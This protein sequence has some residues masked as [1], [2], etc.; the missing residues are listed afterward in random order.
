MKR[1]KLIP[2]VF[3]LLFCWCLALFKPWQVHA[4]VYGSGTWTIGQSS[5][6]CVRRNVSSYFSLT[7]SA[8][9]AG[10]DSLPSYEWGSGLRFTNITVPKGAN[11]TSAN[12][13]F[14]AKQT[15]NWDANWVLSTLSA[16]DS[17]N[18]VTFSNSS[19]DFDNNFS[20]HT[21]A[22][23][24]WDSNTLWTINSTYTSPDISSVLQVLASRSG[25]VSG[26]SIIIYWEDFANRSYGYCD[27][28][29]W[30]YDADSTKAPVLKLNWQYTDTTSPTYTL[31]SPS[32]NTTYAGFACMFS[33]EWTDDLALSVVLF[34]T[35]NTGILTNCTATVTSGWAN[36]TL[37]LCNPVG[38]V[39]QYDW[40]ANDTSNNWN[41]TMPLQSLTTTSVTTTFTSSGLTNAGFVWGADTNYTTAHDVE[42]SYWTT[43]YIMFGQRNNS[44]TYYVYRSFLKFDTSAIPSSF[45]ITSARLCLYGKSD[46]STTDFIIRLQKWTGDTPI[47][48]GDYNQFD[49]TNYD[50]GNFNTA[51]GWD[52]TGYNNVTISN[53]AL[54]TQAGNTF[55][56]LRDS[57]DVSSTAPSIDERVTAYSFFDASD[58]IL[59]VVTYQ[60]FPDLAPSVDGFSAPST[61]YA[62]Q[63]VNVSATLDDQDG[64]YDAL[65]VN[66]T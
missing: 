26:N 16:N 35:N 25:W 5:D 36:Y 46:Y 32:Y 27:H 62:Y 9:V 10:Y 56:C 1:K 51:S 18:T 65:W 14:T 66:M 45:I 15:N 48:A 34:R 21:S 23:V 12:V 31:P 30:S 33:C 61:V 55:I 28:E 13:T 49:G 63:Q 22:T 47:D 3:I 60:P 53:F 17:D 43:N 20:Y 24:N 58:R 6:D 57:L 64:A 37:T 7:D 2:L 44:G 52:T 29:A 8:C 50:D 42:W 54:V 38:A 59:L 40:W 4:T 41:A 11:I 19:T 39:V